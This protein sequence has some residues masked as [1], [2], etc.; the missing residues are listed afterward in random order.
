MLLIGFDQFYTLS[1]TSLGISAMTTIIV[2]TQ[3]LIRSS[4]FSI[5]RI[6]DD[7]E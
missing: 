6:W 4:T 3:T 2:S 7:K 5:S 1:L